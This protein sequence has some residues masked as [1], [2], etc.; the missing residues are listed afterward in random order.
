MY[1]VNRKKLSL[2]K[3]IKEYRIVL[4]NIYNHTETSSL[5][6]TTTDQYDFRVTVTS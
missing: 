6:E 3:A 5:E 2:G 1:L 4:L